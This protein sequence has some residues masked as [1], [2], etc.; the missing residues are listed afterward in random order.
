LPPANAHLS[1]NKKRRFFFI[2]HK[3]HAL[4]RG[5]SHSIDH[6]CFTDIAGTRTTSGILGS[7]C[8]SAQTNKQKKK[9][10]KP[11]WGL[12][13]GIIKQVYYK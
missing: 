6:Y 8:E 7:S 1:K 13:G 2:S 10:N 12:Y 5:T 11:A 3:R 4:V 9:E